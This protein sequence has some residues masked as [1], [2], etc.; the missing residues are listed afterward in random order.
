M[1]THLARRSIYHSN[2]AAAYMARA[3]AGGGKEGEADESGH[4][5]VRP[6]PPLGRP[7]TAAIL[8]V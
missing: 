5:E 1:L 6:P 7:R 8:S 4:L 3:A 2:R